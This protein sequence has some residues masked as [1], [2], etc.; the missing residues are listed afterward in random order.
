MGER[1]GRISAVV[2]GGYNGAAKLPLLRGIFGLDAHEYEAVVGLFA[3][4]LLVVVLGVFLHRLTSR[5]DALRPG[6]WAVTGRMGAGK[7]LLLAATAVRAQ[8]AGRIVFA[9]IRLKGFLEWEAFCERYP[10]TVVGTDTGRRETVW[11][12]DKPTGSVFV[13]VRNWDQVVSVP[14]GSLVLLAELQ[15][16]WPSRIAFGP[17]GVESWVHQ[18]RHHAITCLWDSQHWT[19][20]ST[21]FRKL[22]Y[23]VWCARRYWGGHEYTLYE[24]G[25]FNDRK[26]DPTRLARTRVRRSRA[27]KGVYDTLEDVDSNVDWAEK[28][29]A[30]RRAVV[31]AQG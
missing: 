28:V 27:A 23:G 14:D 24:G 4:L 20:V 15:L 16:W 13:R 29:T 7:T 9:N 19:F 26:P 25:S 30:N 18:I 31:H 22:T 21:R 12:D 5:G 11:L 2:G 10:F 1:G 17:E 6:L 3:A 8:K